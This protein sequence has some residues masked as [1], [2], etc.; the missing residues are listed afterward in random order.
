MSRYDEGVRKFLDRGYAEKVPDNELHVNDGIV[1]YLPHHPV[2]SEVKGGKLRIVMDCSAKL[3]DVSLNNQCLRGPDFVNNLI[4][5]ILRFRQ[6]RYAIMGDIESMYMQVKIPIRDRN[7]LRFIWYDS[8]GR[9]VHYRMTSHVF[10]GVWSG[11]SSTYPLR[12]TC[13]DNDVSDLV[14]DVITRSFYV[15]DLLRSTASLSEARE[16]IVDTRRVLSMGGFNLTKFVVNDSALLADIAVPDRA[17]QVVEITSEVVSKA[18]GTCWD[19]TPDSFYYVNRPLVDVVSNVTQRSILKQVSSMYDPLGL[20]TPIVLKRRMI[21]QA[22]VRLKLQWDEPVPGPLA[23]KWLSWLA[24][25]SDLGSLRFS[26]CL[27]PE[28][29]VDGVA[30]LIHFS[31]ASQAGYRACSYLRIVTHS[32]SIHV[33]LIIS[34]GRLAPLRTVTI[35]WLELCAAVLA[36][37]LDV[38]LRS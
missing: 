17:E 24:S 5:V 2:V 30:E 20:I 8:S 14:S 10:G 16:V 22:V 26:R 29:Y 32:G 28:S 23:D 31:D 3:G 36:V 7:A 12:R 13:Q 19:V 25:L 38:L 27:V 18:L 1:W 21:F 4:H 33:A 15:D 6:Y 35:P 9:L 37:R 34:K 11:S